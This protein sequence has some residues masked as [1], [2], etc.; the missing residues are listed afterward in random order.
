MIPIRMVLQAE[1]SRLL[2]ECCNRQKGDA[3]LTRRLVG[4]ERFPSQWDPPAVDEKPAAAMK[5][6]AAA[7]TSAAPK[8][9]LMQA[10]N[11]L[12]EVR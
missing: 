4:T 7:A 5:S 9:G 3:T 8:K 6:T 11:P 1:H 2:H 12:K 10:L